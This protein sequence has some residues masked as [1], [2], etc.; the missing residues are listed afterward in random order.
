MKAPKRGKKYKEI[1]KNGC[2]G[3][4]INEGDCWY[5]W[6]CEDCPV[7]IEKHK[8]EANDRDKKRIPT[9]LKFFTGE[10]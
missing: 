9:P 10:S 4:Y 8:V 2:L 6:N 5:S 1:V 7:L 3:M